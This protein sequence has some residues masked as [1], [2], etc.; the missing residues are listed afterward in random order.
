MSYTER[1][2]LIEELE[3]LRN[4]KVITLITSDRLTLHPFQGIQGLI[5]ADQINQITEHLMKLASANADL[6]RIDLLVYTRGGDVNTPWPLINTIRNFADEVN[7]LVP[8]HCHSAGTLIALGADK[9]VMTKTATLSPIDPTVANAFNPKENNAPLGISVEDVTSFIALAR[10]KKRVGIKSEKNIKDVFKHLALKVHPLALGNVKRSHTQI[11]LLARKLLELHLK[12]EKN[13]N[14]KKIVNELTEN[15]YTHNHSI[16][17]DEARSQIGLK[18]IMDASDKEE[19][20]M[21]NLYKD[22]ESQ[23]KLKEFFD[24]NIFLGKEAEKL[25]ETETALI[26]S[27]EYSS[28]FTVKQ[29]ISKA[30]VPDPNHRLQVISQNEQNKLNSKNLKVQLI[31][32]QSTINQIRAQI[33]QI[34]ASN[35]GIS[36]N[37]NQI[38]T[39]YQNIENQIATLLGSIRDDLDLTDLKINIESKLE[40]IGWL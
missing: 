7:V 38:N 20:L 12:S 22:Y 2:S 24:P 29:R 10:D 14:I 33:N 35:P 21:W 15:F 6:K 37:F 28:A 32:I 40:F 18:T 13:K 8:V 9:I 27:S 39:A 30:L 23:L 26:E 19:S 25:L 11:R 36:P 31:N 34:V 4:S 1:K 16:F 17:R 3:N 5:G